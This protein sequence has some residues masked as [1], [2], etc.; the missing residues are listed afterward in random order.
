MEGGGTQFLNC[1][2]DSG[3]FWGGARLL[4]AIPAVLGISVFLFF[5]SVSYSM[6]FVNW[7]IICSF[8]KYS[9]QKPSMKF[10]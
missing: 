9:V 2:A 1:F 7:H 6:T 4:S 10:N 3:K 5:S 8:E